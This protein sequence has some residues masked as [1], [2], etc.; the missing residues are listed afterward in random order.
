MVNIKQG[1]GLLEAIKSP[2]PHLIPKLKDFL[3]TSLPLPEHLLDFLL[4]LRVLF[5]LLGVHDIEVAY[6]M[7]TFLVW[8]LVLSPFLVS[9]H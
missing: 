3:V 1:I 6:K 2:F 8:L 4:K 5:F 7:V 9:K